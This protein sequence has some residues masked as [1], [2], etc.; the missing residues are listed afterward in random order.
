MTSDRGAPTSAAPSVLAGSRIYA[1]VPTSD[2]TV[3]LRGNRAGTAAIAA[4][5]IGDMADG[6]G[7]MW[8]V[9]VESLDVDPDAFKAE[10]D[11]A[12]ALREAWATHPAN[13]WAS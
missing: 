7:P 3:Q 12:A 8:Q 1:N 13:R 11:Y 2:G 9:L 5:Y 6:T 10:D 4:R